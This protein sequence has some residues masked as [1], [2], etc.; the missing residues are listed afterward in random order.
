MVCSIKTNKKI[1]LLMKH[2]FTVLNNKK[3]MNV[4]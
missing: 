4:S 3:V 1:N 2:I